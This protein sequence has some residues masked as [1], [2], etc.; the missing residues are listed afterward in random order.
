[1]SPKILN[2]DARSL[3][4]VMVVPG[5]EPAEPAEPEPSTLLCLG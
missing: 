4:I 3:G 2:P 1:M 5:E